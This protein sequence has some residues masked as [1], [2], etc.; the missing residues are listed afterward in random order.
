MNLSLYKNVTYFYELDDNDKENFIKSNYSKDID[1]L[2]E[3]LG[4]LDP[5]YI[6]E[7]TYNIDSATDQNV[8][9]ENWL[10]D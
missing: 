9:I 7:D 4:D 2:R 1:G 3:Y 10:N 8:V 5:D 6:E